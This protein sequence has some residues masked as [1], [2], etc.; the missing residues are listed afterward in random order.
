M[1]TATSESIAMDFSDVFTSN[2]RG[3]KSSSI[4][5]FIAEERSKHRNTTEEER[6][7]NKENNNPYQRSINTEGLSNSASASSSSSDRVHIIGKQL[8]S[9]AG[10]L[11]LSI[12]IDNVSS[13][14]LQCFDKLMNENDRTRDDK[15]QLLEDNHQR[16]LIIEKKE[17]EIEKLKSQVLNLQQDVTNHGSRAASMQA[18]HREIRNHWMNE[19]NELENKVFHI[20]SLLTQ[21]KAAAIK[22]DKD[23]EKMQNQLSKAVKDSTRGQKD[24]QGI[25]ISKPL[26]KQTSQKEQKKAA[27]VKDA[28]MLAS[29]ATI[30][31]LSSENTMLR[32]AVNDLTEQ[33]NTLQVTYASLMALK[34]QFLS[35]Q[36]VSLPVPPS[37][38]MKTPS[39]LTIT[40]KGSIF[41][42]Y[43]EGTPGARPADYILKEANARVKL[44]LNKSN[45]LL[46]KARAIHKSADDDEN[47]CIC[48]DDR[49]EEANELF[50]YRERLAEALAVIHEQDRLIHDALMSKLP[51]CNDKFADDLEMMR[52]LDNDM[53][54]FSPRQQFLGSNGR[55]RSSFGGRLSMDGEALLK[56]F[57]PPASP[58]T[59]SLMKESGFDIVPNE[60]KKSEG[61]DA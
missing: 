5:D 29:T 41:Q 24:K 60:K 46:D 2:P 13:E 54:L 55:R 39:S 16:S 51:S 48:D 23:Y 20:Q 22:K 52:K 47:N 58:D 33:I 28:E 6:V 32:G 50:R 61:K 30:N 56:D 42:T 9:I 45:E 44:L 10:Q 38:S 8:T 26:P 36:A 3:P 15:N 37:S 25:T 1:I 43:L 49:D 53:G 17:K 19:K 35:E 27:T 31:A 21:T 11:G 18:E 59:I 57:L 4:K 14:L 7:D 40:E 12:D 34:H